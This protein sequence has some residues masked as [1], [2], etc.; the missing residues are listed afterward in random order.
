MVWAGDRLKFALSGRSV[1][2]TGA[3]SGIGEAL[4]LECASRGA[5]LALASRN[6]RRLIPLAKQVNGRAYA[7]DVTSRSQVM[8]VV[9]KIERDFGGVDILIN[10]AGIHLFSTVEAMPE[11]EL[12]KALQTNVF[13]PVRMIQAVLPGMK[14]RKSGMIVQIGSTL[15]YRSLENVGGYSATKAA[16]MRLTESLRMELLGSGVKVLDVAPGVVKTPL[17]SNAFFKGKKP[18][19]PES[20]PFAAEAGDTARQIADAIEAGRRDIMP[21]AWPVRLAMKYLS[22][23][24]PGLV[25]LKL[26]GKN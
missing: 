23:L 10:N 19:P 9:K 12:E 7:M 21:A 4:A 8:S 13:G 18:G 15:A 24:A 11:A 3:S 16:L 1:L 2:I 25:D 20:L 5:R 6:L 26:H 17:R 22:V 14:R